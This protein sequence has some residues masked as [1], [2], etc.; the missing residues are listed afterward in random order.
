MFQLAL[1]LSWPIRFVDLEISRSERAFI[2]DVNLLIFRLGTKGISFFTNFTYLM[3][4]Q[5]WVFITVDGETIIVNV[6]LL[7]L[8]N[9]MIK[10]IFKDE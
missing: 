4:R 9:A 6:A 3:Q 8:C 7:F 1:A 10:P 5:E 2:M